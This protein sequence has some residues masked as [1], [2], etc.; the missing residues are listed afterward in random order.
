MFLERDVY[1][2]RQFDIEHNFVS[3]SLL[4]NDLNTSAASDDFVS[5]PTILYA[6]HFYREKMITDVDLQSEAF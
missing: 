4:P 3:F 5:N 2:K 6:W 1:E